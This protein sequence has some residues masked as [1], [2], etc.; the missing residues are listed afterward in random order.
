MKIESKFHGLLE[1]QQED[2]ITFENGIPGFEEEKKFIIMPFEDTPFNILQSVI[3]N[4]LAF[5]TT[6]PFLF[7]KD[8][9]F[10][11]SENV[12]E[13]LKVEQREDLFLLA[14]ITLQDSIESS[15]A[16][17]QAP[18]II[19][20]KTNTGKQVVLH[21]E[22]YTTKHSLGIAVSQEG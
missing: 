7:F 19:N 15:T 1:I 3:T 18:V 14:I 21:D 12:I 16:N 9:E 10:T 22:N 5:I 2:I 11:L 8:Y 6:D 17:L 20:K 13:A 4:E